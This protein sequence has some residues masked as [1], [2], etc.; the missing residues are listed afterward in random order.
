MSAFDK[1]VVVTKKTAL[2]ELTERFNTPQ[3]ALFYVAQ[4]R[5][6]RV[7]RD[8]MAAPAD[9]SAASRRPLPR[10]DSVEEYREA[11]E[12]YHRSLD[13]LRDSIPEGLRVQ[14]IDRSFLPTFTFGEGDLVVTLGP[15]GLVVNTAKYLRSQ[16]LLAVNPDPHRIDGVLIPF[17]IHETASALERAAD[18]EFGVQDRKSTRLNSSH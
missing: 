2:E 5:E 12:A 18:G 1:V 17:G 8:A 10:D 3:Q 13:I 6:Q 15:D 4:A 14:Y 11:H 16:S 7:L 9:S